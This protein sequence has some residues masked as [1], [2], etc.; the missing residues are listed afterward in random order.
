MNKKEKLLKIVSALTADDNIALKYAEH[1]E[2]LFEV[3]IPEKIGEEFAEALKREDIERAVSL[4]ASYYRKKEMAS[5][6]GEIG[7]RACDAV[8][9][10]N[11]VKGLMREVN[12]DWAFPDGE[13]D[14][15]FN[16]TLLQGPVNHEW[17]WQLGRHSYWV[18]MTCMYR[19]T[20]EKKYVEAFVKQLLAW[21]AQTYIPE[22]WNAAGSGWRTI[23]CG[24]RLLGAW[25]FAFNGFR[26]AAEFSDA[27]LLLMIASMHRQSIHLMEHPTQ[28]NWLMMESNGV[29]TFSALFPELRDAEENR[30][31][32][33]ARLLAELEAQILPDG[34]HNELSPDY[35]SVVFNCASNFY[36]L[37]S[38]VGL[39]NEV[40]EAFAELIKKTVHAAV[41]LSTPALTQP[42]TNDTFTIFTDRFTGRAS[43]MF[44]DKGEYAYINSG[45]KEGYSPE[46]ATASAFLPYAGFAVMRSDWSADAAYL[47]FDV[48]PMGRAHVHQD[49]LNINLYKG[50]DE[51]LYDDG[52]GQYEYSD[53][54]KY[55]VSGY[56]H[57][58]VL[59]DGLAQNR[60]APLV[61]SQ[62]IDAGWISNDEYDYASASYEDG[63]GPEM[64]KAAVHTREVRFCKPGFFCVNDWM[65]AKDGMTHSYEV[66]F[67]L[68]TTKVRRVE[69]YP[70]AVISE[71]GKK[72]DLLILPLDEECCTPEL[73]TVSAQTEPFQGWYNGRNESN[74]HEAITVSRVV[75]EVSDYRFTTLLF[76]IAKG[77]ELPVVKSTPDGG[78]EV[79]F[80]GK[81]YRIQVDALNKSEE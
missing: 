63:F 22:E 45:R 62:A 64:V 5:V 68:D 38:E 50:C 47:C 2:E 59:V 19:A 61:V 3:I 26:K 11:A 16:P 69:A 80:D 9:A 39:E 1:L 43:E 44:G 70:N 77:Q 53:A 14:F 72:Y 28:A 81:V 42:R 34:M 66:L 52:G 32:A 37:A 49:K 4:C 15:L 35:Q 18:D 17:L 40:P 23:E 71:F 10:D 54:R 78:V 79:L 36:S 58:I 29:Y 55:A 30:K 7:K 51:L 56:G 41:L 6:G 75:E 65:S 13:V 25:P 74:L 76:P 27:A 73:K 20:G 21:I 33:T 31:T 57:N 48:G 46:G 67:H 24:I 60:E 8:K 12:I